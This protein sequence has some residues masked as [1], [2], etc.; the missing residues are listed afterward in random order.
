MSQPKSVSWLR[1]LFRFISRS[2]SAVSRPWKDLRAVKTN[3]VDI[4]DAVS[5][6][7]ADIIGALASLEEIKKGQALLE[8]R[9][10]ELEKNVHRLQECADFRPRAAD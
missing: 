2:L 4:I 1:R 10:V 5:D 9:T 8:A 7:R 6:L 3:Q